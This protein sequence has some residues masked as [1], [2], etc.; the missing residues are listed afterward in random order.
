MS[1]SCVELQLRQVQVR[2]AKVRAWFVAPHLQIFE[3][4]SKRPHLRMFVPY[5][6]PLYSMKRLNVPME[7]SLNAWASLWFCIIPFTFN[8]SRHT[9]WFSRISL[10]ETL[11]KKSVLWFVTFSYCNAKIFFAFM[12]LFEPLTLRLTFRCALLNL[13]RDFFKCFGFWISSPVERTAN[14]LMPKSTPMDFFFEGFF[15]LMIFAVVST[16]NEAKYLPDGFL[17]IVTDFIVPS[18]LRCNFIFI[19]SRNFGIESLFSSIRRFAWGEE[20]DWSPLCLDLNFGNP[21]FSLKN[22][23]TF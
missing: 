22:L 14:V 6:S 9:V 1:R 21:F 3:L 15:G 17:L 12:R 18:N 13:L 2:S 8:V 7:I 11:C 23:I 19:P 5:H 16:V 20:N 4:A 10:N